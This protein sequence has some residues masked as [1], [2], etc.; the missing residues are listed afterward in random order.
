MK[1]NFEQ[2]RGID[3]YRFIAVRLPYGVQADEA[4]LKKALAFIQPDVGSLWISKSAD[5]VTLQLK[6]Q[7]VRFQILTERAISGTVVV[8]LPNML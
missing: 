4:V 3:S 5:T 1:G 7:V 6:R 2:K 8:W